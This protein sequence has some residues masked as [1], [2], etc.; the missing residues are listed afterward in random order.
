MGAWSARSPADA[1]RA[2]A[3]GPA[4]PAAVVLAP[5]GRDRTGCQRLR[6][7]PEAPTAV[8]GHDPV[9]RG[10]QGDRAGHLT[11]LAETGDDHFGRTADRVRPDLQSPCR[12]RTRVDL[13]WD[14]Q[15]Q[16]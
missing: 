12:K 4:P 1:M 6:A 11:E 8:D 15:C 9:S 2:R 14:L 5:A 3:Q 7:E 10:R 13:R 16:P